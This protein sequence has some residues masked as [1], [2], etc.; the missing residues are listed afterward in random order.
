[1][2]RNVGY[3]IDCQ[4]CGSVCDLFVEE[5]DM[6]PD[7]CPFCGAGV[8]DSEVRPLEQEDD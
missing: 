1:M 4:A 3:L 6:V 5:E 8:M 7:V 2:P